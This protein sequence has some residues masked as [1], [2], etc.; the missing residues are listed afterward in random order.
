MYTVTLDLT[1]NVVNAY[2]L[3]KNAHHVLQY[4]INSNNS[5]KML[6]SYLIH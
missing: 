2:F 4:F 6:G 3:P 5:S 1:M